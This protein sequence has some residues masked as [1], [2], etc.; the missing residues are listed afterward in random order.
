MSLE[1]PLP[2]ASPTAAPASAS[3]WNTNEL[4]GAAGALLVGILLLFLLI[5]REPQADKEGQT[6]PTTATPDDPSGASPGKIVNSIEMKLVLIPAGKF[7]MGSPAA[8]AERSENEWQHQVEITK[9][10]YLGAYEV[11]QAQYQKVMGHN[12]S[13][14]CAQGEFKDRVAGLDPSQFPV[15]NLCWFDAVTFCK[16]LSELP[17]EKKAKRVYRLPTEAEWECACREGDS[18]K[19]PPPFHFGDS[20][21]SKEAN[22]WTEVPYGGAAKSPPLKRTTTVGSY[23]ANKFGLY[24]MHGNVWEW[25]EDSVDEDYYRKSPLKDPVNRSASVIRV[26]RGG[27]WNS[28]GMSCRAAFRFGEHFGERWNCVGFGFRVVLVVAPRTK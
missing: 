25:C 15:D 26:L 5:N 17:E 24:D 21:S 27:S 2:L 13:S 7:W 19:T 20:L 12:P 18:S 14:F 8:E 10:F 3:S 16:K 22:F 4:V 9:P 28:G 23:P 6:S 11:T 1:E